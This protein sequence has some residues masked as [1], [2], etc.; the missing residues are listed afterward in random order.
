MDHILGSQMLTETN[1][2]VQCKSYG[3]FCVSTGTLKI[4]W[5]TAQLFNLILNSYELI[6]LTIWRFGVLNTIGICIRVNMN[7][8]TQQLDLQGEEYRLHL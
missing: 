7:L 8:Y 2:V 3:G 4:I 1:T 6:V 5:K